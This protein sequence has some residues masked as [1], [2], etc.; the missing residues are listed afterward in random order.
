[1]KCVWIQY[2][3][4]PQIQKWSLN[5][6]MGDWFQHENLSLHCRNGRGLYR[7]TPAVRLGHGF[8]CLLRMTFSFSCLLRHACGCW[9]P[10]LTRI[11]M[12]PYWL[13]PTIYVFSFYTRFRRIRVRIDAPHTH[14]CVSYEATEWGGPADETGKTE[15]PCH[16]RCG[17]IEIPPC[18][19][20]LIA[21]QRPKFCSPS[22]VMVTSPYR[23]NIL[24]Q[25]VKH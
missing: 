17:T 15:A 11:V 3:W 24:E 8:P 22:P 9:E 5:A 16:S 2:A 19:K 6:T 14:P 1:M 25:D 21:E 4:I 7:A 13:L 20:A 23:W 12:D 10:I 18:S